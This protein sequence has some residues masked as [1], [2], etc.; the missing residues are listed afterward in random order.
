MANV[1]KLLAELTD[2]DFKELLEIK[3]P[4]SWLKSVSAF[5]NERGGGLIFGMADDKK[6]VGL[7]DIKRDIDIIIKQIK[8]KIAPL[9]TIDF[10][11]YQ[12]DCA[13][14]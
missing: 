3:K 9:P 7:A 10:R 14:L 13:N 6:I 4:K 12:T 8:E 2:C 1:E 5:A 11:A